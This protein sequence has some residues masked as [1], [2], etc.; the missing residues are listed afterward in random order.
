MTRWPQHK[1]PK[2]TPEHPRATAPYNF[3]PLPEAIFF[4]PYEEVE[5]DRLDPNRLHGSIDLTIQT[6]TA[7]Y[8]RCAYPPKDEG[9][10]VNETA[11]RQDF[12]HYEDRNQPMIPGSS[13]R[14]M[15]R[16]LV[17]I[18]GYG[19]I[20]HDGKERLVHR[21]VADQQTATG[22]QY[23]ER[24]LGRRGPNVIDFPGPDVRAG[25]L[26]KQGAGCAIRPATT[27]HGSSFVRVGLRDLERIGVSAK[28]SNKVVP[29]FV[30]PVAATAHPKGRFTLWYA[31][32]PRVERSPAQG[33]VPA[34]LVISGTMPS[35]HMHTAVYAPD[36]RAAEIPIPPD[37]WE[38]FERDR[39]MHR[40]LVCRKLEKDGAPCFYLLEGGKL[41]FLGP[42]LFFR[43]PYENATR[44]FVPEELRDVKGKDLC[45]ALFG[46]ADP[47]PHRGR[48]SFDDA[49][50]EPV[51][52][53]ASPFL[54][55]L[56]D[57]RRAPGILSAPKPKDTP[58]ERRKRP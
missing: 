49:V 32:T 17:A 26:V 35:R 54:G 18:L 44:D 5:H 47:E 56:N 20:A 13:L 29:V 8:T 23:N 22:R 12:Y 10:P 57:G 31:R 52:P 40:G 19:R 14:G 41:V 24:F 1:T 36:P 25:Y 28:E 55:G 30:Q 38:Q 3:V 50:M 16:S 58:R 48:V 42:T 6:E 2:A 51:G 7:T 43:V 46:A 45:D 53:G 15:V 11:S 33:L 39:D 27:H 21:A 9:L 34:A 4:P 37:M